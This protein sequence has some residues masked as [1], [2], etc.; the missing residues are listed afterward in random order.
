MA[1][2]C[3]WLVTHAYS[4]YNLRVSIFR[5]CTMM[6]A[7]DFVASKPHTRD[8][9]LVR[10]IWSAICA[11]I[12]YFILYGPVSVASESVQCPANPRNQFH[13]SV[14]VRDIAGPNLM[15]T[16]VISLQSLGS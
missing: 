13:H 5:R 6:A 14:V 3:K 4:P 12:L 9:W 8:Y 15:L 11:G 16:F 7:S 10:S 2:D 1:A